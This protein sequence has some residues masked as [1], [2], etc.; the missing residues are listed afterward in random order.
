MI[1]AFLKASFALQVI[2]F[3]VVTVVA[4]FLTRPLVKKITKFKKEDTNAGRFVGKEGV[5]TAEINNTL[6]R[7]LVSVMGTTWSAKSE[8]GEI[9]S[10][11]ELVETIKIE[12][13]KLIV[14]KK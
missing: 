8:N 11:N 3:L 2:L 14:R 12:G 13:V 5:V 6:N 1:S 10:E 4:L 7:G 9:I